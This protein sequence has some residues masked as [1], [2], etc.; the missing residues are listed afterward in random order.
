MN[1]P[2]EGGCLCRAVR[3]RISSTPRSAGIC[4]CVSCRLAAGAESVGWAVCPVDGFAFTAAAPQEY[5]SSPGVTR[6]FCGRCGTSLTY[7]AARETI[8]V[9][10]ATLD[11]PEALPPEKE[12]F[13]ESRITWNPLHPELPHFEQS[14][15]SKS[16]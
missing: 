6:T 12:V 10:L 7:R 5:E 8:D 15:S 2:L 16:A 4:H 9:T 1:L 3:Y 13:C 11:D 14:S